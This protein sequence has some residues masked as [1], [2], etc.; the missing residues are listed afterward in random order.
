MKDLG[1]LRY[2]LGLEV[3]QSNEGISISQ[4]KYTMDL[5]KDQGML[6]V[7]PLKLP[8]DSHLKLTADK[9][10]PL[11]NHAAKRLLRYLAGTVNQGILLAS[12]SAAELIACSDSDWASCPNTRRSTTGYCI[13]LGKS[14]ISWKEKKQSVVAK[15]TVEAEYRAMALTACEVTWLK[16]ESLT[17]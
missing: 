12:S 11:S 16:A 8:M 1:K 3:D 13:L 7:K 2:F 10:T 5:L 9:G 6:Q 4:R 15:S 14:P 17:G